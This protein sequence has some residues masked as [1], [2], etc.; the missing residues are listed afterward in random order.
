MKRK[1]ERERGRRK[2]RGGKRSVKYN[3]IDL[4]AFLA[5]DNA[6]NKPLCQS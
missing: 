4:V 5:F 2:E 6:F 1:R 3:I